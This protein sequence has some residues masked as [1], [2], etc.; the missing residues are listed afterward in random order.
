MG[1]ENKEGEVKMTLIQLQQEGEVIKVSELDRSDES[2]DGSEESGPSALP[3]SIAA[4]DQHSESLQERK[5]SN[6]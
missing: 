6:L 4:N 1:K 3:N 2:T 5:A